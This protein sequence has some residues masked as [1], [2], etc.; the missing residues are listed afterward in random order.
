MDSQVILLTGSPPFLLSKNLHW[1]SLSWKAASIPISF[2]RISCHLTIAGRVSN[3]FFYF[4]LQIYKLFSNFQ[5]FSALLIKFCYCHRTFEFRYFAI[6]LQ[7]YEF[8][9]K[10]N[11]NFQESQHLAQNLCW[12]A[13]IQPVNLQLFS[14]VQIYTFFFEFAKYK[15]FQISKKLV[16]L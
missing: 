6:S 8:F 3:V 14:T 10:N 15:Y 11:R 16:F 13:K 4:C 1:D 2:Q 7:I 5:N 12:S 9:W